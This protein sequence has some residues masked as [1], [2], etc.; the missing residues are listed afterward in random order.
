MTQP[1]PIPQVTISLPTL[2]SVKKFGRDAVVVGTAAL[3]TFVTGPHG[4]NALNL[5]PEESAVITGIF[6]FA[7]RW[8]RGI[9]GKEPTA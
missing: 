9:V 1:S 4:V 6:L 5:G 2:R 8:V 7:Y 3:A